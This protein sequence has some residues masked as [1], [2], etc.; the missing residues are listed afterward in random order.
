QACFDDDHAG[1]DNNNNGVVVPGGAALE[2]IVGDTTEDPTV[3]DA[4]LQSDL[5]RHDPSEPPPFDRDALLRDA[6][7]RG[8]GREPDAVHVTIGVNTTGVRAV[9]TIGLTEKDR[10]GTLDAPPFPRPRG[11]CVMTASLGTSQPDEIE[12]LAAIIGGVR[13]NEC[14]ILCATPGDA[15]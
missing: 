7:A 12:R 6:L 8:L 10:L 3:F 9:K 11:S 5:A 13:E 4:L 15:V 1:G 14:L 2:D